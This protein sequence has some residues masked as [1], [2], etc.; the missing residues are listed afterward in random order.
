MQLTWPAVVVD[1]GADGG[2]EGVHFALL[3]GRG[4]VFQV[5]VSD[6]VKRREQAVPG[7]VGAAL[8]RA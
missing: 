7:L 2:V 3:G 6:A 8:G 4:K 1:D 5:L